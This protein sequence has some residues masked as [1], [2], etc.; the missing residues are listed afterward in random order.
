MLLCY[1][2]YMN[3]NSYVRRF[4]NKTFKELPFNEVDA[5]ILAQL[6]YI[7]FHLILPKNKFA[8]F[9]DLKIKG[10]DIY[11]NS[12][13]YKENKKLLPLLMKSERYKNA[14]VGFP[15]SIFDANINKQFY[16]ITFLLPNHVGYISFRGTDIT[17]VG[18]KED[19]Y[20]AFRDKML[21]QDDA[22]KYLNRVSKIFKG[23]F[24]VG[25]HSKGGNL[26]IYASLHMKEESLNRLIQIYSF[27]G[28]GFRNGINNF[29][30]YEI[31]KGRISKYLTSN[32]MI[33][34]I[35][36]DVDHAK[37]VYS[38]G[39]MLGGHDPFRWQV[40]SKA[41]CFHYSK[42]RSFLSKKYEEALMNWLKEEDDE[43]KELAVHIIFEM[44]NTANTVYDLLLK[45]GRYIVAGKK[46]WDSY[47]PEKRAK[48]KEVF[49]MLARYFMSAYSPR[50]F[51][52][53]N[54]AKNEKN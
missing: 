35:Y 34:V 30:R 3:I 28:P 36:N 11:K 21:C 32:D 4:G 39:I 19:L 15:E 14:K 12:V 47:P 1:H 37:I 2:F 8:K 29:P 18:W 53:Q 52:S 50:N 54:T 25:G 49:K 42:D 17:M 22:T 16:A 40:N 13:D 24:Y 27:D 7:D 23:N 51:L 38:N 5:L 31:L 10:S 33:G 20:L 6:S 48:A 46:T 44:L 45:G 9:K 43:D 26:A 41:Q